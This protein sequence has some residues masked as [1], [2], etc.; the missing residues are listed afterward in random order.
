MRLSII[1]LCLLLSIPPHV[2]HAQNPDTIWQIS[3]PSVPAA[4]QANN[5]IIDSGTLHFLIQ[6]YGPVDGHMGMTGNGG[7]EFDDYEVQIGSQG[8]DTLWVRDFNKFRNLGESFEIGRTYCAWLYIDN[9][10]GEYQVLWKTLGTPG[11]PPVL[12]DLSG[13]YVFKFRNGPKPLTGIL[14]RIGVYHGGLL[15]VQQIYTFPN[16]YTTDSAV[17]GCVNGSAGEPLPVAPT[18]TD[19]VEPTIAPTLANTPTPYPT[20][21]PFPT[22]EPLPTL[23]PLATHTLQ[24]TFTP[25]PTYTPQ[26][27]PQAPTCETPAPPEAMQP[28]VTPM[29]EP[30]FSPTATPMPLSTL[31]PT[32]GP[33]TAESTVEQAPPLNTAA[34]TI[35]AS[36]TATAVPLPG[37]SRDVT[38][39]SRSETSRVYLPALR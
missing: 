20:Y 7:L 12:A 34:P 26:P 27:T 9:I 8:K 10:R 11:E 2:V 23:K 36:P 15:E 25:Y 24:P 13:E 32:M 22:L 28:I 38:A 19:Y 18:A 39:P 5:Q 16:Q 37:Q 35:T 21:T 30:T 3:H 31:A 33:P 4:T 14:S 6:R 29:A 1:I 17:S